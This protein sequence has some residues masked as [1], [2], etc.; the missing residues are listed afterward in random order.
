MFDSSRPLN[1]VFVLDATESCHGLLIFYSVDFDCEGN[2]HL[3]KNK[4]RL[5]L[6]SEK[7][8]SFI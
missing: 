6:S 5:S 8:L 3:K 1:A 2:T 4:K 7:Q